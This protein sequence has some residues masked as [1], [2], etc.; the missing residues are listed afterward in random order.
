V[1]ANSRSG[2]GNSCSSSC[3]LKRRDKPVRWCE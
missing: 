2:S 1:R 3:S